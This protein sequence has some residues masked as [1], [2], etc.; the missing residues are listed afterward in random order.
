MQTPWSAPQPSLRHAMDHSKANNTYYQSKTVRPNNLTAST[1]PLCRP[2]LSGKR[3]FYLGCRRHSYFTKTG[4]VATEYIA[5]VGVA[6]KIL[7]A[8]TRAIYLA[9]PLQSK[10]RRSPPYSQSWIRPWYAGAD[11]GVVRWVRTNHPS[12]S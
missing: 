8:L 1:D 7:R 5:L 3:K 9:P 11:P 12:S 10:S 2:P 6:H 4:R